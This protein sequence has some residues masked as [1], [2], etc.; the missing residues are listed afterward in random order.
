MRNATCWMRWVGVIGAALVSCVTACGEE[1]VVGGAAPEG[2]GTGVP[3]ETGSIPGGATGDDRTPEGTPKPAPPSDFSCAP[4]RPGAAGDKT[5]TLTVA[6]AQRTVLVHAAKGYDPTKGTSLVLAFHGYGGSAAQ[7]KTQ[8][9]FD[10]EADKRNLVVAYAEGT[11]IAS[12]G[13][14]GGD[15][16]GA[17]AWTNETDD[18][19]FAREIAKK[20]K[21]DYCIDPKR[22]YSAG[23]SNGGF[24]SYRFVCEAANEFAAVASVSGVL[25]TP[26]ESCKPARA[27]PILHVHGT[28]DTTVPYQGG[29]AAGGLG[30]LAGIS[31][32]SVAETVST[33]KKGFACGEASKPVS[34]K[35]DTKCEAWSGCKAGSSIELCTVDGGGHQ[36][37]G[38]T[39]TASPTAGKTSKDFV[40]ST[41]V[42]DFFAAHPMP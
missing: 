10:A 9:G 16:C 24:M 14:N 38:G 11:G 22:V 42:L 7:M 30:I 20:L 3:A 31:F 15:C 1:A 2:E 8:T 39:P 21:A 4:G 29:P 12:K 36:W 28:A 25:G 35:G 26:P 41:A 33:F 19:A 13:F 27:V 18:L 23:F 6:G 32:R 17:P 34:Q 40:A 37:P 5:L